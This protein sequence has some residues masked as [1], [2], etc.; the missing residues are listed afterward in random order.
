LNAENI[1]WLQAYKGTPGLDL[2]L[3]NRIETRLNL[4]K[5]YQL[6]EA[7]ELTTEDLKRLDSYKD[8]PNI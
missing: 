1:Q 5:G 3:S 4:E 6:L 8:N 2:E 7:E